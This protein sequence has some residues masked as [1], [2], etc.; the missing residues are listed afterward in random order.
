MTERDQYLRDV[1]DFTD[2]MSATMRHSDAHED[3]T[4]MLAWCEA[5]LNHAAA[6]LMKAG[7][8]LPKVS[9]S[10]QPLVEAMSTS[11]KEAMAAHGPPAL[12]HALADWR[13]RLN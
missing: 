8:C 5:C 2:A 1:F 10:L 11:A 13:A 6:S 9:D 3:P 12:Q 7:G 4:R